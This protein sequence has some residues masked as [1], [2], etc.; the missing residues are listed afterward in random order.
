MLLRRQ[1]SPQESSGVSNTARLGCTSIFLGLCSLICTAPQVAVAADVVGIASGQNINQLYFDEHNKTQVTLY[2]GNKTIGRAYSFSRPGINLVS[3]QPI[4][5]ALGGTVAVDQDSKIIRGNLPFLNQP[6]TISVQHGKATVSNQSIPPVLAYIFQGEAYVDAAALESLIPVSV[7]FDVGEESLHLYP[8]ATTQ[9]ENTSPETTKAAPLSALTLDDSLGGEPIVY[10]LTLNNIE[11]AD[12]LEIE[13]RGG[14]FFLPLKQLFAFMEFPIQVDTKSRT[15]KGWFLNEKNI[16]D[17]NQTSADVRANITTLD[18]QNSFFNS[19]DIYIRQ[20]LVEAWFGLR[21]NTDNKRMLMNIATSEPMPFEAKK[22]REKKQAQ[23]AY[24][25]QMDE[26]KNVV[27]KPLPYEEWSTP[28]TDF[29]LIQSY[30]NQGSQSLSTNYTLLSKGDLG[31]MTSDLFVGGDITDDAVREA[32]L[33]LGKKDEKATLL[34]SFKATQFEFGDIDSNQ[35]TLVGSTSQGRGLK[36]S[37]RSLYRPDQFDLTSF[38]GNATP[39]WDAELYRNGVLLDFQNIGTDGNYR[40]LNVPILFGKNNFRVVLYGPQGQI[41]EVNKEFYAGSTLLEAGEFTYNLS[42]DEKAE[43]LF[44]I[45]DFGPQPAGIRSIGEVEY[46]FTKW[47]TGAFGLA[48]TPLKDGDHDYVTSGIRSSLGGVLGSFDTA[49]DTRDSSYASRLSV[50]AS[51]SDIDLRAQ[52]TIYENF[53]SEEEDNITNPQKQVYNLDMNTQMVSPVI[54]EL[55]FGAGYTRRERKLGDKEDILTNRLSK[56]VYG[57]NLT[58]NLS[59]DFGDN[60]K[61]TNNFTARGFLKNVLIGATVDY[62]MIPNHE[63][64]RV[65]L[66]GQYYYDTDIVNRATLSKDFVNE[67]RIELGNIMTWDMHSFGLSLITTGDNK[68]SYFAGLGMNI[69]FGQYPG[70]GRWHFQSRPMADS[71]AVSARAFRDNNNNNTKDVNEDYIK[72]AE[73]KVGMGNAPKSKTSE[74]FVSQLVPNYPTTLSVNTDSL[75]YPMLVPA[76]DGVSILPRAGYVASVDFPIHEA[77][78]VEGNFYH[79]NTP[80]KGAVLLLVDMNNKVVADSKVEFD[81]YYLF[82]KVLPGEYYVYE[83]DKNGQMVAGQPPLKKISIS[84]PDFYT[85]IDII[86]GG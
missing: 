36:L 18:P 43:T 76:T 35:L 81:G 8:K 38:I 82:S 11:V 51:P 1:H 17:L 86:A 52:H 64:T 41:Q 83:A 31:Y 28:I 63:I 56:N 78:E 12:F 58:N 49:Y 23:F 46:G 77:S 30:T 24:S 54:G 6:Y 72:D 7:K 45:T 37:N 73:F 16:F 32:R 66:E 69:S 61:M 57:V 14:Q 3:L 27:E 71:G 75:K 42:M 48:H 15:A 85:G 33:S 29:N 19:N 70:S 39:G 47:L 65:N 13:E 53:I 22:L 4:F 67:G 60:E 50:F 5:T 26:K 55:S 25:K 20:D 84:H 74:T 59:Y 44:G 21:F 80:A 79:G 40:F 9:T 62:D 68:D 34:G 2:L 10:G